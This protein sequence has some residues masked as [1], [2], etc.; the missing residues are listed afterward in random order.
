[1]ILDNE[2]FMFALLVSRNDFPQG[3][4]PKIFLFR[5]QTVCQKISKCLLFNRV[6]GS[7]RK[8]VMCAHY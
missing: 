8:S 7:Q 3:F 6:A 4:W 1:M 5:T 2:G